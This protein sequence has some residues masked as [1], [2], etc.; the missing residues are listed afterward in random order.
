MLKELYK[1][2][3]A[4][5]GKD[6][7]DERLIRYHQR[8]IKQEQKKREAGL[9]PVSPNV[10][11][12]IITHLNKVTGQSYRIA[13]KVTKA[14]IRAR[15]NEGFTIDDFKKVHI[16]KAKQWLDDDKMRGYLAPT[17]LYRPCHF[18]RYLNEYYLDYKEKQKKKGKIKDWWTFK[19]LEDLKFYV[20]QLEKEGKYKNYKLPKQIY[21]LFNELII[22]RVRG[23]A[24]YVEEKFRE[25]KERY[26]KYKN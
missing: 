16:I 20:F 3:I 26:A 21:S 17:T 5:F 15:M 10:Y 8:M 14:L 13:S 7:W 19:K 23:N 24:S 9:K 2:A 11:E 6:I 18:E 25:I 12:C 1:Q 22:E 4:L